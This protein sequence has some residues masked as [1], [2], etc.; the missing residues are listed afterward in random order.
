MLGFTYPLLLSCLPLALAGIWFAYRAGGSAEKKFVPSLLFLRKYAGVTKTQRKFIPPLRAFLF[1][2]IAICLAGVSAGIYTKDAQPEKII[3]IDNSFGSA[4][5]QND[6]RSALDYLRE[7][8]LS[9]VSENTKIYALCPRLREID[10]SQLKSLAAGYCESPLSDALLSELPT[11]GHLTVYT[12]RALLSSQAQPFLEVRNA[13]TQPKSNLALSDARYDN[14]KGF[15]K[16]KVELTSYASEKTKA[17]LELFALQDSRWQSFGKQDFEISPQQVLSL[18]LPLPSV[19][20]KPVKVQLQAAR[21]VNALTLDDQWYLPSLNAKGTGRQKIGVLSPLS[22]EV[23]GLASINDFEFE[24]VTLAAL[25]EK[26][27]YDGLIVHRQ[28]ILP[29][30]W[31]FLALQLC[32]VSLLRKIP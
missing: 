27:S 5:I 13:G 21:A 16:V 20:N 1:A 19:L 18:E 14:T 2:L 7:A 6:T 15:K 26:P 3:L 11:D 30:I 29:E 9:A 25:K 23:L 8:A 17:A 28:E 31:I 12:K 10:K 4:V 24:Q 22:I 32:L